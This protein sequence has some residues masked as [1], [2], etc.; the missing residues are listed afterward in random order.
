MP[1]TSIASDGNLAD[2]CLVLGA[3]VI[4]AAGSQ[5]KLDIAKQY[6]GADYTVNYTNPNWP[7]EVLKITNGHGAD[8][9]Y[10]PVGLIKGWAYSLKFV[11]R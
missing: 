10:D 5:E 6:G 9:I 11:F 7:K 3:K 8:V 2:A 1:N 4:A